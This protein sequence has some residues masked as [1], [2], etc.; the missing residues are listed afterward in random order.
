MAILGHDLRNPLSAIDM[1]TGLL[2]QRA[3]QSNDAP[4][5]RV[6][7]RI[8]TSTRRMSRMIEQILDLSRSRIG[9]GLEVSPAPMDLCL[10]LT[11]I[12]SSRCSRT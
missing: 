7:G 5:T 2:G 1:A 3:A 11:G 6:L 12:A 4:T 10:M 8:G 9:G